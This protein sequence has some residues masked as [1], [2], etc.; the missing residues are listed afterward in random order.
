MLSACRSRGR[1][2]RS[3][4]RTFERIW[5]AWEVALFGGPAISSQIHALRD[6]LLGCRGTQEWSD[7]FRVAAEP[8]GTRLE[9]FTG[10]AYCFLGH[11]GAHACTSVPNA[12]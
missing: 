10:A 1:A 9:Y 8:R 3:Q 11:H 6:G 7:P 12:V 4:R 2:L 5:L